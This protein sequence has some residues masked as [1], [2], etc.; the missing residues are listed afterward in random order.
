MRYGFPYNPPRLQ[1]TIS[2]RDGAGCAKPRTAPSTAGRVEHITMRLQRILA[3]AIINHYYIAHTFVQAGIKYKWRY[4]CDSEN[5]RWFST[6]ILFS[7]SPG[8]LLLYSIFAVAT[9]FANSILFSLSLGY[10]LL[11]YIFVVAMEFSITIILSRSRK[12]LLILLYFRCR[13]RDGVRCI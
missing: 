13:C 8:Y 9:V 7:L 12:Y 5:K 6:S 2:A 4:L 10:L 3:T 1:T 11:Y